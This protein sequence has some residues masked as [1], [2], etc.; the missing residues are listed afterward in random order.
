MSS[1]VP[2]SW[3]W[4]A[5]FAPDWLAQSFNNGWTFGNVIQVTNQNSSAPEVEREVVSQYSYGKQIGQI[6]EA[7][8]VISKAVPAVAKN[9][10]VKKLIAMAE[11]IDRLKDKARQQRLNDLVKELQA[12][13]STDQQ[14]WA[15]LMA[16]L[17]D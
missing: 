3:P 9:A 7:V 12:L 13:K 6:M 14:E 1:V 16:L 15:K 2:P 8:V 5:N 4:P 10:E 11:D 17:E